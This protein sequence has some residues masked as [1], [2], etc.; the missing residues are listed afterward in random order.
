MLAD[1][2]TGNDV[3]AVIL[4]YLDALCLAHTASDSQATRRVARCRPAGA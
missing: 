2:G 4:T 3:V 1:K